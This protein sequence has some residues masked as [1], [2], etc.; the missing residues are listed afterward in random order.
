[1]LVHNYCGRQPQIPCFDRFSEKEGTI[2]R[3]NRQ[4]NDLVIFIFHV[5]I[6]Y[7]D[8]FCQHS[9]VFIFNVNLTSFN[10]NYGWLISRTDRRRPIT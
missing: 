1:M 5:V 9:S 6:Y 10:K 8:K 2:V 7:P 3:W 4:G